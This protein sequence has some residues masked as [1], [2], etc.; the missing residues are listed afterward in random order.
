MSPKHAHKLRRFTYKKTGNSVYFCTF[1]DCYF[2]VQCETMLG[3]RATCNLCGDE[4]TMTEYQI[5]LKSPHCAKC[6]KIKVKGHDG[7]K[8]YVRRDSLP[9]SAQ[10]IQAPVAVEDVKDVTEGLRARLASVLESDEDKD[11]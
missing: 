3:K 8:H 9:F 10:I 5:K 11:I 6:S 4:F 1:P 2:R 7:K